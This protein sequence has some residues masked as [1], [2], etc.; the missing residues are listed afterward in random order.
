MKVIV[1]MIPSSLGKRFDN[2]IH[3]IKEALYFFYYSLRVSSSRAKIN[4]IKV[5]IQKKHFWSLK[6][7]R[8]CFKWNAVQ[9]IVVNKT[10][11]IF[12]GHSLC[13]KHFAGK[14]LC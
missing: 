8:H 5:L 14:H 1:G 9:S 4:L 13:N 3:I 7:Q 12:S 10:V 6:P 11:P 2:R